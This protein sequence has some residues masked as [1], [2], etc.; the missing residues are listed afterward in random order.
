MYLHELI[1]LPELGQLIDDGFVSSRKHPVHPL[2]ILNYTPA[3]VSVKDWSKTL[4]FCRGLVYDENT[5]EIVAI[6]FRKFWNFDDASKIKEL[7]KGVPDIYEKCDGSYLNCFFYKGEALVSTRGSFESEQAKWAQKYI[8][9]SINYILVDKFQEKFNYIFE[10]IIPEDRKVV[11]YNFSGLVLLGATDKETAEEYNPESVA[12]GLKWLKNFKVAHKYYFQGEYND[13][14]L[15]A[16][17][18]TPNQEGFVAVY[19]DGPKTFRAKIKFE[20][21]KKL[22]RMYFQTTPR[23]IWELVKDNL[24]LGLEDADKE[25]KDWAEGIQ[26]GLLQKYY[27]INYL[28]TSV[29]NDIVDTE[30]RKEFALKASSYI[31]KQLL[32]LLLDKK[33]DKYKE[34]IWKIIEPSNQGFKNE[35]L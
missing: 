13:L 19:Y 22:H 14:S 21:Y 25:L 11:K 15:L 23:V 7:P 9:N 1:D 18:D 20:T 4:E 32:F 5:L 24:P 30:S 31:Y 28:T 10:V 8:D 12:I 3:A 33:D 17:K 16:E 35:S 2:V 26:R 34:A 27:L 29:F 6:P